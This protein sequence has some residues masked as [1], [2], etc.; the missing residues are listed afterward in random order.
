MGLI[1]RI[2]CAAGIHERRAA[3]VISDDLTS[4]TVVGCI[5]C[6]RILDQ[7]IAPPAPVNCLCSIYPAV[8]MDP[9]MEP[10]PDE[11]EMED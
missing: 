9:E 6:G 2:L 11:F 8:E 10:E 7:W 1:G 5:R 3:D 4:W